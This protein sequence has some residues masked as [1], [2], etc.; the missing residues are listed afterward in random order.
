[1][2]TDDKGIKHTD[3]QEHD[4]LIEIMAGFMDNGKPKV[5]IFWYDIADNS[6]FGVEKTDADKAIFINGKATINKLHKT[7]WQKQHHR[8]T[9]KGDTTSIFYTESNYTMIPRGRI[10]QNE[11]DGKFQVYVGHWLN[12]IDLE[13]F[14]EILE[15]E[16][17]L[18]SDFE[19]V[20]DVH[21]DLG[22][23]WSEEFFE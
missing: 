12:S 8:A 7:Y 14:R 15:D 5:G 3:E 9:A 20:V 23:G 21:W 2:T 10:F 18:P 17:N 11:A 13:K 22:H 19:F 1:M 6:L 4:E 16:F